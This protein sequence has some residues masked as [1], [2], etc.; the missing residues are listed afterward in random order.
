M[1]TPDGG[2]IEVTESE[3]E[4]TKARFAPIWREK[5][6]ERLKHELSELGVVND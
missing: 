3:I 6:L 1:P 2:W 5:R 4:A